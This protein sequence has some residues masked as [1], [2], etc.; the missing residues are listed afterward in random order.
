MN[1]E[2]YINKQ[3]IVCYKYFSNLEGEELNT[4]SRLLLNTAWDMDLIMLF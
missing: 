1:F 3:M 2:D 4:T